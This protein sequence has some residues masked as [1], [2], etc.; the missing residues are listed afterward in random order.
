MLQSVGRQ[1]I[2]LI[3]FSL[4]SK[5]ICLFQIVEE[6]TLLHVETQSTATS[7]IGSSYSFGPDIINNI[8]QSKC[9][10]FFN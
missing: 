1:N 10:I 7:P 3:S 8:Q 6:N 4:S 5:L 2:F 9:L